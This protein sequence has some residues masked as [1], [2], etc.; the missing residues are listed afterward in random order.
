MNERGQKWGRKDKDDRTRRGLRK[1][2]GGDTR[3]NDEH[4]EVIVTKRNQFFYQKQ[5]GFYFL[6][7]LF[8]RVGEEDERMCCSVSHALGQLRQFLVS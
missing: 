1:G 4:K 6:H 2:N 3:R 5:H 7:L 8:Y